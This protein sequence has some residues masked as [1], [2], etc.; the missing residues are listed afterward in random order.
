MRKYLAFLVVFLLI[1]VS[2]AGCIDIYLIRDMLVPPKEEKIDYVVTEYNFTHSF[3]SSPNDPI[4]IY[5]EVFVVPVKPLTENMR[6]DIDV[7]MRSGEEIWE[8]INESIPV[9][10]PDEIE[11]LIEQMLEIASQRYIQITIKSPDEVEWFSYKFN[12]TE[13]IDFPED[14]PLSSPGEGEWTIEVEGSGGG[15]EVTDEISYHDSFSIV[16]V[17]SE[18]KE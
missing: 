17:L 18:P 7:V 16:V 4:E 13:S 11:E 3:T 14:T 6:F 1:L 2:T 15:Y 5:N 8:T 10:I 12:D 9:D